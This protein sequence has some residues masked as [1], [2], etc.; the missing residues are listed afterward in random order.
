MNWWDEVLRMSRANS[1]KLV[2]E[3]YAEPKPMN[4]NLRVRVCYSPADELCSTFQGQRHHSFLYHLWGCGLWNAF[5]LVLRPRQEQKCLQR[6]V[7]V[8]M[9]NRDVVPEGCVSTKRGFYML[10][11]AV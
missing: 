7:C 9:I 2:E 8:M 10:R 5:L 4:H 11:T 1:G 6:I 3:G